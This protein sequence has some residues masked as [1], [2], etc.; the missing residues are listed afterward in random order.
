MELDTGSR[1]FWR[2]TLYNTLSSHVAHIFSPGKVTGTAYSMV[3]MCCSA[4]DGLP[5]TASCSAALPVDNQP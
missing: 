3:T 1:H 5:Y 4:D 2:D